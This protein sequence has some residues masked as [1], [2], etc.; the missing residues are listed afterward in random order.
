MKIVTL[1]GARPQFIKAATVARA[2]TGRNDIR[3]VLIHTGQHYDINMSEIFFGELDIPKPEYNL[4]IGSGNHGAQTG[5]MLGAIEDVLLQEKP[6]WVLVYGDTNSTIAGTL[7][8]VKL[9]LPVA[10][11]E[12][13]LRSFNRRM[14]EEVNRVLTD[15]AADLLFAPTEA[16]V[17][18]LASEGL[19]HPQVVRTGD[20]MYDAA[21][22][23][24][25]VAEKQSRVLHHLSLTQGG[26]TLATLHRAENTDDLR[27]LKN[28][29]TSL[30]RLTD[31]MPVVLPLHP[32]TRAVLANEPE[33]TACTNKIRIVDPVGYLDMNMLERHARLIMTDSG[34]VQKEAFFARVPCITL[35]DETEWVELVEGGYNT[36]AGT[37]PQR[38][39]AAVERVLTS[40]PDWN[41]PL[42]GDGKA[43]YAIIEHLVELGRSRVQ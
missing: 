42:Y 33:L 14:P 35:R 2:V 5:R 19:E 10:H 8:A 37:C 23:Y 22:Y 24:A 16:A 26:Y 36:I 4:E 12:A 6:D 9:H 38:I 34:G 11:V 3:H 32:R 31:I 20:V 28:I 43:A 15:H 30:A 29:L 13:G 7:A 17:A 40:S 39:A 21:L 27:R 1:V 41:V 18:N 25:A